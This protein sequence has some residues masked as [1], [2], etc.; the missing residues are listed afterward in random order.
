MLVRDGERL[1]A[2]LFLPAHSGLEGGGT[3]NRSRGSILGRSCPPTPMV[4]ESRVVAGAA[5]RA[6]DGPGTAEATGAA[7]LGIFN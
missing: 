6:G 7:E 1:M 5:G 2:Q 3:W 4:T